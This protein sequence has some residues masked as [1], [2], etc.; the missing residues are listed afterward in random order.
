[1]IYSYILIRELQP[2]YFYVGQ[3]VIRLEEKWAKH[4]L[5]HHFSTTESITVVVAKEPRSSSAM[6]DHRGRGPPRCLSSSSLKSIWSDLRAIVTDLV[7]ELIRRLLRFRC[8]YPWFRSARSKSI[9]L[10]DCHGLSLCHARDNYDSQI[11][12][13]V[14]LVNFFHN[15]F[16]SDC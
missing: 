15:F 3:P 16:Y 5:N 13:S 4:R 9:N 11:K 10:A 1:M 8:Q 14:I 7:G 2:K 6:H 12:L